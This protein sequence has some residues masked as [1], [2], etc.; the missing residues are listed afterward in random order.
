MN[1]SYPFIWGHLSIYQSIYIYNHIYIYLQL[2]SRNKAHLCR[3]S[4]FDNAKDMLLMQRHMEAGLFVWTEVWLE[5]WVDQLTLLSCGR[6]LLLFILLMVQ[7][8]GDHQYGESTL[9]CMVWYMS[10]FLEFIWIPYNHVSVGPQEFNRGKWG[11][12]IPK[13]HDVNHPGGGGYR[14]KIW[15]LQGSLPILGGIFMQIYG[16]FCE[17]CGNNALFGL[18]HPRKLT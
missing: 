11:N 1:P 13:P 14:S 7:K 8:S 12:W 5:V 4:Q 3:S 18:V 2:Y 15:S 16:D 9:I 6:I 10:G 17:I